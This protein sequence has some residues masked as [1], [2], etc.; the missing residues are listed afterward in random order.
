M[1]GTR[2]PDCPKTRA[3]HCGPRRAPARLA[4]L[5]ESRLN[6][7]ES[8]SHGIPTTSLGSALEN[9]TTD[10]HCRPTPSKPLLASHGFGSV[11]RSDHRISTGDPYRSA[12][13]QQGT[14]IR[15]R[16]T[17][18]R[19]GERVPLAAPP[20]LARQL[21]TPTTA[22][23]DGVEARDVHRTSAISSIYSCQRGI[24]SISPQQSM[25]L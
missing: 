16:L 24:L 10:G 13:S 18:Q 2:R 25:A 23:G 7:V 11:R 22:M 5:P 9:G 14:D 3:P 15:A 6:L 1:H 17:I 19:C 21:W 4:M 12:S 8:A 20:G